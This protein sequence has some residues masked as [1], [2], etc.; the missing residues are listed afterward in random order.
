MSEI[1]SVVSGEAEESDTDE[2][3]S[4]NDNEAGTSDGE[5]DSPKTTDSASGSTGD[6]LRA[7]RPPRARPLRTLSAQPGVIVQGEA[8][9][10]DSEEDIDTK[11][12]RSVSDPVRH[13]GLPS[14]KGGR[15]LLRS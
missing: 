11:P 10:T 9:E 2:E 5:D 12:K 8:S 7:S 1:V 4:S 13:D 14:L 3:V 15:R 6:G